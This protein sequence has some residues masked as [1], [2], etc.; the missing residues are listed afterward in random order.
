MH[1]PV[2]N[3]LQFVIK[4]WMVGKPGNKASM[5]GK[6]SISVVSRTQ[7]STEAEHSRACKQG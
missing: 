5:E 1:C 2:F 3:R 6:R 7:R 4:N